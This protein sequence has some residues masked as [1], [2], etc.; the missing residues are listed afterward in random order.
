[1]I[2][3]IILTK[4]FKKEANKL[5]SK[6]IDLVIKIID[7]LA[8]DEVLEPKYKDHKLNGEYLGC[9]NAI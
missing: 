4:T 9:K 7:R 6:T 8:N 2:Y 1:M 5:D 3:K